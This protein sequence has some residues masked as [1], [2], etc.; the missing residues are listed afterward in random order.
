MNGIDVAGPRAAAPSPS[1]RSA[2]SCASSTG[3]SSTSASTAASTTTTTSSSPSTG[4][5]RA[6]TRSCS[7]RGRADRADHPAMQHPAVHA[8]GHPT[9]RK[10]GVRPGYEIDLDAILDAARET[11]TALEVNASPRRLDLSGD[12]V[13]RAVEAG[14]RS[15]SPATPTPSATS[16]DALRRGDGAARLGD[17]GRRLNCRDLDGLLAFTEAKRER[18]AGGD[19]LGAAFF[20]RPAPEVARPRRQ[21]PRPRRRRARRADRR[22]RG[23]HGS[24]TRPATPTAAARSA[25]SR[26]T[27]AGGHAYVYFTYGMHWCLNTA[28][29]AEGSAEGVLLRAAEPLE[30]SSACGAARPGPSGTSC[31]APP[32]SPRPSASTGPGAGGTCAA[33]RASP[34]HL[35]DDGV[36][37]EVTAGPRVG[38]SKAADWPWRFFV[39]RL[40][41]RLPLHP[42]PAGAPPRRG[43]GIRRPSP[44]A[45]PERRAVLCAHA[46]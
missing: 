41:L 45:E 10:V 26:C 32:A 8:I 5:S 18:S 13:R 23:L 20:A 21:A 34:L 27:A 25:T 11:G 2:T 44:R 3:W 7:G 22:D 4:T 14:V 38:V 30:A 16:T 43:A 35:A 31:A 9:G 19:R 29:G 28:T 46:G 24:T 40:A 1:C 6:S 12:M 36:R 33:R 42:Q 37:P 15:R 39:R 17:P